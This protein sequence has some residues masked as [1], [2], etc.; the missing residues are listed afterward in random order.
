MEHVIAALKQALPPIFLGSKLDEL[1]GGAINWRTT[2]NRRC[3]G[4]I[5]NEDEIF[6]RVGNRVGVRRDPLLAWF[7]TT[8]K[9]LRSEPA[10]P[11]R[12]RRRYPGDEAAHAAR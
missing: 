6:F 3:R 11:P 10:M 8:L 7:A 12:R 4:E 1:T 5:E 9:P 2:Q